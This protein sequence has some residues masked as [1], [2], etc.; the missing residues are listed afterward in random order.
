MSHS[1]AKSSPASQGSS[2]VVVSTSAQTLSFASDEEEVVILHPRRTSSSPR[3]GT[4]TPQL[5]P[6]SDIVLLGQN[7]PMKSPPFAGQSPITRSDIL[8]ESSDRNLSHECGPRGVAI[9]NALQLTQA[10][11]DDEVIYDDFHSTLA[12]GISRLRIS[13]PDISSESGRTNGYQTAGSDGTSSSPPSPPPLT[14]NQRQ[15]ERGRQAKARVR[16]TEVVETQ[17][18][19][20]AQ[21]T[22]T[23]VKLT[24]SQKRSAQRKRSQ[25]RVAAAGQPGTSP[26]P[27]ISGSTP[28]RLTKSQKCNARRKRSKARHAAATDQ[29]GTSFQLPSPSIPGPQPSKASKSTLKKHRKSASKNST[30]IESS[31]YLNAVRHMTKYVTPSLSMSSLRFIKPWPI[32][33]I[34]PQLPVPIHLPVIRSKT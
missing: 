10:Q 25:A 16:D 24:K 12:G 3:V 22:V 8:V 21:E 30:F 29:P 27:S 33:V 6:D 1:P 14:K 23:P 15:R 13:S 7:G 5:E 18:T 20:Q 32:T 4:L 31:F 28:A 34:L 26:S 9:G 17:I 11:D 2:F 19:E